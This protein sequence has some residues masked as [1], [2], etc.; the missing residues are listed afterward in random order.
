[1]DGAA[2]ATTNMVPL[3]CG[4]AVPVLA[5]APVA[6]ASAAV[7]SATAAE[8]C[9]HQHAP[10]IAS[11]PRCLRKGDEVVVYGL[12]EQ[13]EYDARP[14]LAPGALP[15]CALVVALGIESAP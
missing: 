2:Q 9:W 4:E 5:P 11:S 15:P 6:A 3:S 12:R 8:P 14:P 7:V 1:M 13:R 10:P